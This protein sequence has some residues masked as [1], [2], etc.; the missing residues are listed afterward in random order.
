M[1]KVSTV[2]IK[3]R[4]KEIKNSIPASFFDECNS[5]ADPFDQKQEDEDKN[6]QKCRTCT[7]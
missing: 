4:N 5:N 3:D 6:K 7:S 1:I 2:C